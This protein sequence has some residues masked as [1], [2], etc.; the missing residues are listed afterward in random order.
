MSEYRNTQDGLWN[1]SIKT[2]IQSDNIIY[3]Y[4]KENKPYNHII[5]KSNITSR[6]TYKSNYLIHPTL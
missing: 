4:A 3:I 5:T 1:I 6:D 2:N